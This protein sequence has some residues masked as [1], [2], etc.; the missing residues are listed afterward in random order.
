[1]HASLT[2]SGRAIQRTVRIILDSAAL[3][4]QRIQRH[5]SIRRRRVRIGRMRFGL[6]RLPRHRHRV[7]SFLRGR[8]RHRHL[9]L[10]R[11]FL[12]IP[13]GSTLGQRGS[14]RSR[15]EARSPG[16]SGGGA[17][18]GRDHVS[19]FKERDTSLWLVCRGGGRWALHRLRLQV[20]WLCC[21]CGFGWLCWLRW[22]C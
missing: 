2:S 1:M 14:P 11:R 3:Q 20:R 13:C 17:R 5:P 8:H 19:A 9:L 7:P 10:L 6:H 16:D 15:A 18:G 21:Q 4:Q 22:L 12:L